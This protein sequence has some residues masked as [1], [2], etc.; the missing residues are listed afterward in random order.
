MST[1][2]SNETEYKWQ[3]LMENKTVRRLLGFF[4]EHNEEA[5]SISDIMSKGG[6][7]RNSTTR[8]IGVLEDMDIVKKERVGN[9]KQYNLVQDNQIVKALYE[10]EESIEEEMS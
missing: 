10:L 9:A 6:I 5:Y 3:L 8:H 4:M 7:H 2:M 1:S